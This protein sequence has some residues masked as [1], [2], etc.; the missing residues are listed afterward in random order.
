VLA[1][2]LSADPRRRVLL[3]EAGRDFPPGREPADIADC[4]WVPAYL[5]P[6]YHWPE[7]RAVPT[8]GSAPRKYEQARLLGGGSAINAQ[9]ANRGSPEDYA[10][11]VRRG[12]QGWDWSD[13]LPYFG[14]VEERIPVSR[15]PAERWSG[16]AQAIAQAWR[17]EGREFLP[18]QNGEF[19][20][21]WFPITFSNIND[22]RVT[23]AAGYLDE[24][25]RRRAN[26]ELATDTMVTGLVFEGR[27]CVGVRSSRGELRAGEVILAAGA[28]HS[29][30][31]LLRAGIG[32]GAELQRLGIPLL[33][34]APRVGKGLMDHPAIS[35]SAYV[36]PG[37]RLNA[38]AHRHAVLAL[39]FTSMPGAP[40]SDMLA[41]PATKSTWHAVGERIG[42][43]LVVLYKPFSESGE[44]RLASPDWRVAPEVHFDLLSERRDL[45]RMVAAVRWAARLH[46]APALRAVTSDPFA[47]FYSPRI[48]KYFAVNGRNRAVMSLLGRLLDSPLRKLLVERVV[49]EAPPVSALLQDDAVCE[50]FIR[51]AA[52]GIW[53]ASCTCRMGSVT[54]EEGRVRGVE[55]LRV[56]DASIFPVAPRANTN[57]PVMMAAEKIAS[58]I[59]RADK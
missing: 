47:A 8:A 58:A 53:H 43:V 13:V 33:A 9:M 31:L 2:R 18:D 20:D 12:A 27:R 21:G 17:E 45:E 32:P 50:A 30:A 15:V 28:I 37:A 23:A 48:R 14:R 19:R 22:R 52:T 5:N 41:I 57:F 56:A 55:G 7:L 59:T 49:T 39:R 44:V 34:D 24:A 6:A 51:K 10:E 11:W 40:S 29:P 1:Q 42:S 38:L 25:T 35:I 26:L 46:D 3:C 4:Y 36:K 54:D 16:H